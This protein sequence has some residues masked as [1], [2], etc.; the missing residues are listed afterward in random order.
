MASSEVKDEETTKSTTHGVSTISDSGVYITGIVNHR[1]TS[2]LLDTGAT[3]CVMN[4]D[5]WTKTGTMNCLKPVILTLTSANG[6]NLE[7]LGETEVRFRVGNVD[8]VWPVMIVRGLTH[9]CIIGSDFFRYF[10]CQIHYDTGT[11]VIQGDEVPIR[12]V[13]ESPAVCRIFLSSSVEIPPGT[14]IIAGA[15][16]EDG[17][18]KNMGCPGILEESKELKQRTEVRLA[19]SMVVPR[20]GN[21]T[22][23]L[24]NFT[25]ETLMLGPEIPLAEYH[26]ISQVYGPLTR[27]EECPKTQNGCATIGVKDAE[28]H[29]Q[30]KN[31]WDG[32]LQRELEQDCNKLSEKERERFMSLVT[33]Y[34][35]IF[36][37]SNS[38]LGRTDLMEHEIYT[39]DHQPIKQS[40]R[41]TPPHKREVIDQQLNE[42]LDHGRIEPSQ[43]PWSS[44]VVL[45]CKHDGTYRMCIDYRRLNQ[46]TRKAALPLPRTDDV[47]EAL[48][49]AQWF[50]W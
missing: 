27:D 42:L 11:F 3:V 19:R 5:I 9:D 8:C 29:Q 36:A 24:A 47:L 28:S 16:V 49:G 37:D 45:A 2:V 34:K 7:V 15:R 30:M 32:K 10:G 26:P 23:R 41:H 33:E 22:V 43:S 50:T 14:E 21:T 6:N 12:Y 20:D 25:D 46:C 13:K 38:D 40:P 31:G 39:G 44:P 35:D 4:E 48:G 18:N 1:S 17:Y